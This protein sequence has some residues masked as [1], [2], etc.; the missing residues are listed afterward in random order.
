MMPVGTVALIVVAILVYFGVAHRILD[1]M[2]L[3][4]KAAVLAILAMIAGSF[5]NFRIVPRPFELR[6]NVGGALVPAA[7][8]IYLLATTDEP[9]E[10]TRGVIAMLVAGGAI[11]ALTKLLPPEEQT[12]RMDP[13][14]MFGAV[15]ALV[16]YLI[17]RSRRGAFVGGSMGTIVG[18]LAHYAEAWSTRLPS[19]TWLGGAG[20]FD[21]VVIGGF[22]AVVLA[23]VFGEVRERLQAEALGKPPNR[24]EAGGSKPESASGPETPSLDRSQA[25]AI[26][27]SVAEG[28]DG[29]REGQAEARSGGEES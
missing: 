18:D 14:Y 4:D 13:S 16:A 8:S 19:R 17:G 6:V 23:E 24:D 15:S 29:S 2:R 7:I 11:Y 22:L 10:R 1:R 3:N 5:L 26:V 9:G 25:G 28:E 21:A 12:M 20:A 27:P